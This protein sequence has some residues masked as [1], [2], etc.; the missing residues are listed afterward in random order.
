MR[1]CVAKFLPES[2]IFLFDVKMKS[3]I[4][5]QFFIHVFCL[6]DITVSY[7][8]DSVSPFVERF[9]LSSS[10]LVTTPVRTD[11]VLREKNNCST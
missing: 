9:G 2:G 7:N 6:C 8:D 3:Q 5:F 10:E 1:H 11:K 4:T